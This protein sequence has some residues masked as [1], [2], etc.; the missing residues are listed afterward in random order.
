MPENSSDSKENNRHRTHAHNSK[1]FLHS[2]AK[3][4]NHLTNAIFFYGL[5]HA[6]IE[7]LYTESIFDF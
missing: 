3:V 1:F 6:A 2:R 5:V 4:L 7:T